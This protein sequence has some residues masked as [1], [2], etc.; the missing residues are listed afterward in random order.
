M[1]FAAYENTIASSR[2]VELYEFNFGTNYYRYT[3]GAQWI[4]KDGADFE[5]VAI[6]RGEISS[7]I[8]NSQ[9]ML[10]ISIPHTLP[11][12]ELFRVQP[13]SA[14]VTLSV[15]ALQ[16]DDPD[17]Q[18]ITIWLGRV[19]NAAWRGNKVDV[20]GEPIDTSLNRNGLR[21][22]YQTACPYTL[23]GP[24]CKLN[25]A[26]WREVVAAGGYSVSGVNVTVPALAAFSAKYFA[27]GYMEYQNVA[28]GGLEVKA[29]RWSESGVLAL[30]TPPL[31]LNSA[32]EIFVYPG[33]NHTTGAGGCAKF[34]NNINFGG[35]PYI[36]TKSPFGGAQLF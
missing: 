27:G 28:T 11:V 13:P 6:S 22:H 12:A 16:L 33:C 9:S 21:R 36:P 19:L 18:F 31:Y 32:P 2:P 5:P 4:T 3:S 25:A 24:G 34:S 20:S 8:E 35:Q 30:A 23:F 29:I 1:T 14:V 26:D 7:T 10:P 17:N 15:F